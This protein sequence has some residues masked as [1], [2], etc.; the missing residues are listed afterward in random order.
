MAGYPVTH[1]YTI[2]IVKDKSKPTFILLNPSNKLATQRTEHVVTQTPACSDD[3]DTPSGDAFYTEHVVTDTS[4]HI[5]EV[6][7]EEVVE[8]DGDLSDQNRVTP[9]SLVQCDLCNTRLV[10]L[11]EARLHMVNIHNMLTFEGPCFKCDF[12]NIFVTDRVSHM[13]SAHYSPLAQAFTKRDNSY[14]CR[15]CDYSSDQLTNIR[16]HVD[17]KHGTGE[18][19]Y[20]CE[21]CNSQYRTLNSMRAHKSRV[22]VKR[23]RKTGQGEVSKAKVGRTN[24]SQND[25]REQILALELKTLPSIVSGNDLSKFIIM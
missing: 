7:H 23:R 16:N 1:G 3:I 24:Q 10:G 14:Q 4:D 9:E 5:P 20:V 25:L 21:E 22:H 6:A 11:D 2:N 19:K 13:K 8:D 18:N 17:A 12:C 15:A